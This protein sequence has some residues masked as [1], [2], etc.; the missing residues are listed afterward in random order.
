MGER[1][2]VGKPTIVEA[3]ADRSPYAAVFEDDGESAYF[4]GLDTRLGNQP[5]LDAV[6]VYN[7][8]A[9]RDR[10]ALS[11]VEIRWSRDQQRVALLLNGQAHAAFDFAKHRGY[12]R[13]N[14]PPRSSWSQEGHG[15]D[16]GAVDFLA[17]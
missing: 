5:V 1:L 15:W 6:H 16:E 11:D 17:E 9:L 2:H 8:G 12:C 7:V 3:F 14:F 10:Q 13:S 4:Y